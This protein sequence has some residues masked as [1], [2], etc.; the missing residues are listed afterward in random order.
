MKIFKKFL[1]FLLTG[2]FTLFMAACYGM[3]AGFGQGALNVRTVNKNNIP[4]T[5]L[6]I[7][8]EEEGFSDTQLTDEWGK[9]YFGVFDEPLQ[10]DGVLTVEDID[11]E[12][13]GGS[14]KSE[15]IQVS[16]VN[17]LKVELEEVR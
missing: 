6:R 5:G 13:N 2:S 12:S 11:D 3:P 9:A 16:G 17:T 1:Q 8:Y 14:F 15:T 4:L 10:L 7:S